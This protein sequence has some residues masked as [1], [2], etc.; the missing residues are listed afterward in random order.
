MVGDFVFTLYDRVN[1]T[2]KPDSIAVG[3]YNVDAH[4]A[5]RILLPDGTVTNEGC[6][7]GWH[8]LTGVHLGRFD[9]PFRVMLPQRGQA[10]NL[11]V[12]AAVSASHVGSGPLRLEPQYMNL[13]HAAGVAASMLLANRSTIAV[14][15]INVATLQELLVQQGVTIHAKPSAPNASG[16][17]SKCFLDRC[18]PTGTLDPTH[19]VC[20][21]C[22]FP[23]LAL[24]EW[25]GS[26]G[27]WQLNPTQRPGKA[28]ATKITHLKKSLANSASLPASM[29]NLVQPGFECSLSVDGVAVEAGL[30]ACTTS[31]DK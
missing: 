3:D 19:A 14:Q 18:V 1:S 21:D 31:I 11:L 26:S 10:T 13:G 15:N 20:T 8:T 17:V 6:L 25:L 29:V 27:A 4:M 30:F 2:H 22:S 9:I 28:V 23:R 7:S 5:Q 24:N 12:S 16:G